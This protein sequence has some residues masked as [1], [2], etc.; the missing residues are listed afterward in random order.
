MRNAMI[1]E[2]DRELLEEIAEHGVRYMTGEKFQALDYIAHACPFLM[3]GG[4]YEKIRK[5]LYYGKWYRINNES[6]QL[7]AMEILRHA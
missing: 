4:D 1:S 7:F 3:D 6:L 5:H 2:S